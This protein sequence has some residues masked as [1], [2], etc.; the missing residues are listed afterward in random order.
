[1]NVWKDPCLD[2]VSQRLLKECAEGIAEPLCHVFNLS[3]QQGIFPVQWKSARVQSIYKQKGD[4]F[5]PRFYRPIA[6]LLSVPKVFEGFVRKQL[7]AH[8]LENDVIPDE[9]YGFL[10]KRSVERQLLVVVND[11]ERALEAG[12]CAHTCFLDVVKAFDRVDHGILLLK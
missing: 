1:M 4:R 6:L 7:L 2:Y 11:W 10:P 12:N 9:Q 3:L 5:D 8:C